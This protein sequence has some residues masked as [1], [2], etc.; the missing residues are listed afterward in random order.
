M[1]FPDSGDPFTSTLGAGELALLTELRAW[2]LGQVMGVCVHQVGWQYLPG[3]AQWGGDVFCSLD[4]VS[5]AW[6]DARS[7]AFASMSEQAEA[8][9]ADAVVGVR[10]HQGEHDWARG[11]VDYLVTGTAIRSGGER[12]GG[13]PV[14]TDLSGQ[15]YWKLLAAGWAP[16]GLVASTAVFFIAQSGRVQFR[17]RL[18][19]WRNQ[20]LT[21]YSRG[22]AAA[23]AAAV[24][25]LR[26]QARLAGAAGI[27][28]VSLDYRIARTRIR[29]GIEPRQRQLGLTPG[30]VATGAH[31]P[32]EGLG[33]R[34]G[35]VVTFQAVG[36]AIRRCAR[37]ARAPTL[38]MLR[39]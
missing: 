11:T 20:E 17:R 4:N 26:R 18:A 27:V 31:V 19:T 7:S 30:T 28:G 13:E 23:R 25:R 1:A 29:V 24:D 10:V 22:F 38:T 12:V 32:N 3:S 9:G 37:P 33:R 8:L 5:N 15:E 34:A 16:A 2:P 6:E 36:T 35:V 39:V 14:L 21:E